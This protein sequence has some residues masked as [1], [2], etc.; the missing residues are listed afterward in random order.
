MYEQKWKK[1]F[2][3]KILNTESKLHVRM[4]KFVFSKNCLKVVP[5]KWN[6]VGKGQLF[7]CVRG[8]MYVPL[9]LL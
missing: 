3:G 1:Q 5:Q 2:P 9:E 8:N 4:N 7:G 6:R